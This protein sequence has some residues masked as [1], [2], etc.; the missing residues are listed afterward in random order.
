MGWG[1]AVESRAWAQ[2]P[3]KSRS[4]SH[5]PVTPGLWEPEIGGPLGLLACHSDQNSKLQALSAGNKSERQ[6]TLANLLQPLQ[7]HANAHRPHTHKVTE[8]THHPPPAAASAFSRSQTLHTHAHRLARS[9]SQTLHAHPHRPHTHKER[10]E[11]NGV[12]VSLFLHQV[13]HSPDWLW[14]H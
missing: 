10:K 11:K 3:C 1:R 5:S 9:S 13:S 12:F 8:N 6:K 14:I 4:W 2:H 7:V